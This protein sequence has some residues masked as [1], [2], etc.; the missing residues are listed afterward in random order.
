MNMDDSELIRHFDSCQKSS[1]K[2]D[3]DA[4]LDLGRYYSNGTVIEEDPKAAF[5]CFSKAAETGN[6]EAE[7]EL[8]M[9]YFLGVGTEMDRAK[10]YN[11]ILASSE[12][13]N[14]DATS[15]LGSA[16]VN[17]DGVKQN[18]E[19]GV[20][21]L[22][23][24]S[25]MGNVFAMEELGILYR[26]GKGVQQ[27]E[28]MSDALMESAFA[29]DGS[30]AK[31]LRGKELIESDGSSPEDVAKGRE[32]VMSASDDWFAPATL[33]CLMLCSKEG[34]VDGVSERGRIL[35]EQCD[36][37]NLL[38]DAGRMMILSPGTDGVTEETIRI[39]EKAAENGNSEAF[40]DLGDI[41]ANRKNESFFDRTRSFECFMKAA[42]N[43]VVKAF[44][45]VGRAYERGIGVP[46]DKFAAEA[47]FARGV[48]ER[49]PDCQLSMAIFR[50]YGVTGPVNP[51]SALKLAKKAFNNGLDYAAY[52][53]GSWYER[54]N[55]VKSF[56]DALYWYM[57]GAARNEPGCLNALANHYRSG[58]Y[59][60]E[61]HGKAFELF[62]RLSECSEM[63]EVGF[64]NMGESYEKGLGVKKDVRK[65]R[66]CYIEAVKGRN[67]FAMYRLHEMS[68]N[69]GYADESLF[70]L[71][72]S[73]KAGSAKA[74]A[75]LAARY[76]TGDG[77]QRSRMQAIKWYH[78]ASDKGDKDAKENMAQLLLAEEFE[79]E[80]TNYQKAV[81]TAA[82]GFVPAFNYLALVRIYG[83]DGMRRN[84][85][86]GK[87]WLEIGAYFGAPECKENIERMKK[88][89]ELIA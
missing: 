59:V 4:L 28:E 1:V 67:A 45:R 82:D 65:A 64:A 62:R 47:W 21:L 9:C 66:E 72:S 88:G 22:T 54:W 24:A 74:M 32:L 85:K 44:F 33:Y 49:D 46:M 27:D 31:F 73:A 78:E 89:E 58:T 3:T 50:A 40:M 68:A 53:L 37:G 51:K 2:G 69:S 41:Y 42:E 71:M 77:V 13:G 79:E 55:E 48:T 60:R 35:L 75:E 61:D 57:E 80:P 19:K 76:E 17:G 8:G 83:Q 14:H 15:F 29:L 38:L 52:Q 56:P 25:Y 23:R 43:G 6:P 18:L 81:S 36:D 34:D 30:I 70:W 16:Y 12:K 84:L 26:I 20:E 87:R 7:F 39:L 5:E 63:S 10:G 11:L 86:Q